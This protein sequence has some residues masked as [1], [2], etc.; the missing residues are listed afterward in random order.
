MKLLTF[1]SAGVLCLC[2]AKASAANLVM[3]L[4]ERFNVIAGDYTPGNETEGSALVYGT[5]KPGNS[6][7]FGFNSGQVSNDAKYTLWLNNGVANTN[8]TT[9]LSGSLV[10]R[11]PVTSSQFTLNGNAPGTPVISTGEGAWNDALASVGLSSVNHL[12]NILTLASQQWSQMTPNSTATIPGNGSFTFNAT[13]TL[14]DGTRVAIFNVSAATLFGNG[15]NFDRLE[16]N[17][18]GAETVLINVS[19]TNIDINKN[20]TNGFTNNESKVLFN[21]FEATSMTVNRNFRGAIFAPLANV[22]Q[23]GSN[24][25]GS[26]VAAKLTQ[27]AEIHNVTFKGNLPA[28]S[29]PEPS[30]AILALAGLGLAFRRKR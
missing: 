4:M 2:G 23:N 8:R 17:M 20:F 13:P 24:F 12:T 28:S 15:G 22:Q 7:Q 26:V 5:Y 6:A 29:I 14:I 1:L 3:S 9:L 30:V 25:D 21:F 18:N 27:T 11:T 10:S 16:L 19:G